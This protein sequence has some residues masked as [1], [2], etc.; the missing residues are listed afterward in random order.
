MLNTSQ[1]TCQQSYHLN[2]VSIDVV[3]FANQ[4]LRWLLSCYYFRRTFLRWT[5]VT[6]L[7]AF[8]ITSVMWPTRSAVSVLHQVER[9]PTGLRT[10]WHQTTGFPTQKFLYVS[11]EGHIVACSIVTRLYIDAAEVNLAWLSEFEMVFET[12]IGDKIFKTLFS[13]G[14]TSENK[15]IHI[16]PPPPPIHSKLGCL[17]FSTGGSNSGTPLNGGGGGGKALFC[18]FEVGKMSEWWPFRAKCL[19]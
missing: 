17:L 14:I 18:P 4:T 2:T 12:T 8:W 16:A 15:I 3:P 6:R 7:G 19:N 9:W 5:V 13:N 1:D 10:K 11:P